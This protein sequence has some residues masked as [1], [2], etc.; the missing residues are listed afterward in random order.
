MLK[1]LFTFFLKSLY[2]FNHSISL[3][4]TILYL[5]KVKCM[6]SNRLILDN[7]RIHK[8]RLYINTGKNNTIDSKGV[9]MTNSIISI[10]GNS[11]LLTIQS[12]VI[13]RNAIIIIRGEY[14]SIFIGSGTTFGEV[15]IINVGKNNEIRIGGKCL[16]SDKI[17]IWASDTHSIYDR[18]GIFLNPELPIIIGDNV[19]VGSHVKILKGV[20][21][22][23]GAIIGMNSLVTKNIQ[24]KSLNVGSPTRCI[25]KDVTWALKY[26]NE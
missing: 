3:K 16:F 14:C 22:G 12:G 13:L 26:M 8:S 9:E 7:S 4:Q 11:N 5:T 10:D 25:K 20:T 18:D 21:I 6:N 1:Y 15:R 17:E 23:D 24:P 2:S 19:W